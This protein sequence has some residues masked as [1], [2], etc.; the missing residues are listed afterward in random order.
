MNVGEKKL[1][2]M[3]DGAGG[4]AMQR[5][6]TRSI[7]ENL[8]FSRSAG[9]VPLE[10]LDDAAVVGDVVISTD[11]HTVKPIF[12]PG[13]DIGV[14]SVA[15]TVNDVSSLGAKPLALAIAYVVEE[16]FPLEDLV[17]LTA[18]AD[19][20]A[21]EAGVPIVTGDTKVVERGAAEG[22][23]VCTT[24]IGLPHHT[25]SHNNREVEAICGKTI[26]W[27]LDSQ[28]IPGAA[29]ILSGHVGD[30]GLAVLAQREGYGFDTEV[31]SDVGPVNHLVEAAMNVRGVLAAKDPT[32]GG[33][34]NA[35]NEWADKSGV[36]I[37][38]REDD[39]PLRPAVLHGCELLG[40][41]PYEIGNEGKML[42][43]VVPE[44]ADAIVDALRSLPRGGDAAIIGHA[45]DDIEGVVLETSVGGRRV[46]EPPVSDPVPR[47]C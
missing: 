33:I 38:L 4:E 46:L 14:L 17:R 24:G 21:R 31:V 25:L 3:A 15:G 28:V 23:F 2:D 6:I 37:V 32:R 36:G 5:F 11:M 29:I 44:R 1:V 35:I 20:T 12:F 18:S 40:I 8:P 26:N 39:I 43:A 45:T 10:S 9:E 30:H 41:D 7:L 22:I 47:I 16:G 42:M 27:L 34:A 13:G 19:A